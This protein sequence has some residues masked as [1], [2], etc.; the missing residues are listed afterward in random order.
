MFNMILFVF[1]E[2]YRY[3]GACV[4]VYSVC[5]FKIKSKWDYVK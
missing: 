3:C 1:F 5:V 2:V 4:C